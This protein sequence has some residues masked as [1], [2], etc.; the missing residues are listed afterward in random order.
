MNCT[1]TQRNP[2]ILYIDRVI[3][4]SSRINKTCFLKKCCQHKSLWSDTRPMWAPGCVAMWLLNGFL[5]VIV[6][7]AFAQNYNSDVLV[8]IGVCFR[9]YEIFSIFINLPDKNLKSN[10]FFFARVP[11]F[12]LTHWADAFVQSCIW[13]CAVAGMDPMTL[14]LLAP[15]VNH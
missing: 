13:V 12:T 4:N 9:F 14:V 7:R 2:L 8:T 3:I 6:K 1:D 11:L 5:L 15:S 10:R